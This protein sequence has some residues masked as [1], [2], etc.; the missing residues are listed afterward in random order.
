MIPRNSDSQSRK[1]EKFFFPFFFFFRKRK[2]K[3]VESGTRQKNV[4]SACS[5]PGTVLG[6]VFLWVCLHF[7]DQ[8]TKL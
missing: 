8:K 6:S 4:E 5:V 7:L 3:K 2:K 1:P